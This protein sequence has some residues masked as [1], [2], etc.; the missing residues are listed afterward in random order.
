MC[1][2]KSEPPARRTVGLN[3]TDVL[4]ANMWQITST[5]ACEHLLTTSRHRQQT[6]RL[7]R[8]IGEADHE[9]C[10]SA[11]ACRVPL[12]S[13]PDEPFPC[14]ISDISRPV[15]TDTTNLEPVCSA[16]PQR[17]SKQLGTEDKDGDQANSATDFEAD[18]EGDSDYAC[19]KLPVS[20]AL[21][22]RVTLSGVI[23]TTETGVNV[24]ADKG[25]ARF[26]I[27]EEGGETGDGS[28]VQYKGEF[29]SSRLEGHGEFLWPNGLTYQGEVG[30]RK[31]SHLKSTH[32]TI[33][34]P[35]CTVPS[36]HC[37]YRDI[38]WT[39][40]MKGLRVSTVAFALRGSGLGQLGRIPE[41]LK[42]LGGQ[43]SA[44]PPEDV[45]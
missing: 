3:E 11:E 18:S 28:F 19:L 31:G 36:P 35:V 43:D 14:G 16:T 37:S 34:E 15:S 38:T 23:T 2:A 41:R 24:I 7:R 40:P 39:R 42:V 6:G 26:T 10:E 17:N 5:R 4:A 33:E 1:A 32:R 29:R 45:I 8:L 21:L 25:E 9:S 22:D 44:K 27:N 30:V 20:G 13:L 12:T